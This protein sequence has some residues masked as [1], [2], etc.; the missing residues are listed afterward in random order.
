MNSLL[1]CWFPKEISNTASG[2]VPLK[3]QQ[4]MLSLPPNEFCSI[5]SNT[6]LYSFNVSKLGTDNALDFPFI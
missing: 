3:K 2:A 5:S 1:V 4:E 6:S